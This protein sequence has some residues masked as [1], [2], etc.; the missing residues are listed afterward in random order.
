MNAPKLNEYLDYLKSINFFPLDICEVH[1]N[2]NILIQID[3]LFIEKDIFKKINPG[4]KIL[5]FLN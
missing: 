5:N 2:D 4:E 1:K 3:I